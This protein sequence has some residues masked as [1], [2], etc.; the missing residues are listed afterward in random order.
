MNFF[1]NN[2]CPVL[3]VDVDVYPDIA[4]SIISVTRAETTGS[5]IADKISGTFTIS[6]INT[7]SAGIDAKGRKI[8][9]SETVLKLDVVVPSSRVPIKVIQSG[10]NFIMQSSLNLLVPTFVRILAADYKRWSSGD[11]SRSALEGV[12]LSSTT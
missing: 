8:L 11:D 9:K 1:G 6:A 10:G 3:Y 12:S 2:I 5:D 4:T 7:V